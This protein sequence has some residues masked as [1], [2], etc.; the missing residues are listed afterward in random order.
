MEADASPSQVTT[1]AFSADPFVGGSDQS[2]V[3]P[4]PQLIS[5]DSRA[6][7]TDPSPSTEAEDQSALGAAI[8]PQCSNQNLTVEAAASEAELSAQ[9]QHSINADVS[10]ILAPSQSMAV[11]HTPSQVTIA[12]A[13]QADVQLV[14]PIAPAQQ[15]CQPAQAETTDLA[16]A[17]LTDTSAI[18]VAESAASENLA[19]QDAV[20]VSGE[21]QE[22]GAAPFAHATFVVPTENWKHLQ[23][24]PLVTTAAEI[25]HS[26]CSNWNIAESAL[27]VKYNKQEIQD[28][29]SLSSCG[30]QARLFI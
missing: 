5:D 29:Q 28:A 25:K 3:E 11:L 12:E 14:E 9:S 24:V 2:R 18:K 10:E 6:A 17:S 30:I 8:Q 26:L 19:A 22:E 23:M 15:L 21:L 7:N 4:T 20:S 1:Q 16:E 13:S 27:S